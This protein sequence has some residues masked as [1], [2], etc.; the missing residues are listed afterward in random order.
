[1]PECCLDCAFRHSELAGFRDMLGDRQTTPLWRQAYAVSSPGAFG[2]DD[3][4]SK[5][6]M[7][8]PRDRPLPGLDASVRSG[9]VLDA[10]TS[11]SGA[12]VDDTA[13]PPEAPG[14]VVPYQQFMERR[15]LRRRMIAALARLD[16]KRTIDGEVLGSVNVD[17]G[18]PRDEK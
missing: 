15:G 3:A 4:H 5:D 8:Q 9:D 1:V 7:T 16:Q 11:E 12:P 13:N 2:L 14:V 10:T 17:N 6:C 18:T